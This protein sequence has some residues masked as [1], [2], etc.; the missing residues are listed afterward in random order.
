MLTRMNQTQKEERWIEGV[1]H[2]DKKLFGHIKYLSKRL[3]SYIC[4]FDIL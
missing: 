2:K 3:I 4:A 1:V